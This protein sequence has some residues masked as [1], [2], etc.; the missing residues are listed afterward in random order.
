M[1][2][3]DDRNFNRRVIGDALEPFLRGRALLVIDEI[4][5]ERRHAQ[6][7]SADDRAVRR[8]DE[9]RGRPH[10]DRG[11]VRR[12][13][14][15]PKD[16]GAGTVAHFVVQ[17]D[18]ERLIRRR[19]IERR[20]AV[21]VDPAGPSFELEAGGECRRCGQDNNGDEGF[22]QGKSPLLMRPDGQAMFSSRHCSNHFRPA[23][24]LIGRHPRTLPVVP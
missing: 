13:V 19:R 12:D 18:S 20:A 6:T 23:T 15:R 24:T 22:E 2:E 3:T 17:A 7:R 8:G 14:V 10:F 21:A 5:G 11:E 9:A 16:I 4:L 1:R